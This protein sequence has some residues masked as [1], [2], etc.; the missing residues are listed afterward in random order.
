LF[1]PLAPVALYW[2]LEDCVFPEA[3][4][5]WVQVFFEQKQLSERLLVLSEE[6]S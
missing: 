5:Y 2:R 6:G 3:G 4:V 1:G